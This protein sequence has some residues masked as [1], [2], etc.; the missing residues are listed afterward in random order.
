MNLKD[1]S[2]KQKNKL[3]LIG[4]I[5]FAIVAYFISIS[6]TVD[7]YYK[8][9]VLLHQIQQGAKAPQNIQKLNENLNRISSNL[10]DYELD[11][12]HNENL[13]LE[14]IGEF[15]Q[16]HKLILRKFPEPTLHQ[17][18]DFII[19][20]HKIE[21]QGGY[22]NLIKLVYELEQVQK[23]GRVTSVN[24]KRVKD[25]KTKKV[26]LIASIYLQHIQFNQI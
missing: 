18:K 9:E 5:V 8:N 26:V 22:T 11:S 25:R 13:F 21:I 6:D 17:E 20:T 4:A 16:E 3:M 12:L 24:Y 10:G 2:Y 23:I 1:L 15:C 7:A 19:Y 14:V